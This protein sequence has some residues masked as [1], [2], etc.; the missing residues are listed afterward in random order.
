MTKILVIDD[1]EQMRNVL[2]KLLTHEG[3]QVFIAEDGVEGIKC[4]Y[5]YHPDLVITDIIMPNKD[6]FAVIAEI[7]AINPKQPIIAMSGGRR[8]LAAE[9]EHVKAIGT[10]GM[11]QKPFTLQQLQELISVA[12]G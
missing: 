9:L 12:L 2:K 10:K 11:L 4:C 1:D 6:G 7:I 5:R 8:I 3:Y